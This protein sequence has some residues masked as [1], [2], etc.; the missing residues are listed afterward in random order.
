LGK[1]GLKNILNS[2][3]A[4]QRFQR[5]LL[6]DSRSFIKPRDHPKLR[7][8]VQTFRRSAAQAARR[9][10]GDRQ[11]KGLRALPRRRDENGLILNWWQAKDPYSAL[12]M[13]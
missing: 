8:Y 10:F 12:K 2:L 6:N 4:L 1:S 9:A 13:L 7:G 5:Q 11:A 3:T